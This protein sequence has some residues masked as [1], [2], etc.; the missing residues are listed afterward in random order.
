MQ[1]GLGTNFT[2]SGSG[3]MIWIGAGIGLF[4]TLILLLMFVGLTIYQVVQIISERKGAELSFVF[5]GLALIN[6]TLLRLLA[7]FSGAAIAFAGLAVSFFTHDKETTLWASTKLD[8]KDN[9]TNEVASII[10]KAGSLKTYSPGIIAIIVGAI[11]ISI[12]LLHSSKHSYDPVTTE[13]TTI[14][15]KNFD[16]SGWSNDSSPK[17]VFKSL[18]EILG[19]TIDEGK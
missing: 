12:A 4:S 2:T 6:M 11:I 17:P 1:K 13:K 9:V 7:I 18:Q 3:H 16:L 19:E 14:L 10:P 5:S 8:T 15:P